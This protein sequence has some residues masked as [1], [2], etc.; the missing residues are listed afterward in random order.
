MDSLAKFV[1]TFN[2]GSGSCNGYQ[3]SVADLINARREELKLSNL[4]DNTLFKY[5][6]YL[7]S[8]V[9]LLGEADVSPGDVIDLRGIQQFEW[10]L[11][12]K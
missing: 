7:P 4:V 9:H 12:E 6:K 5:W 1:G 10:H 2:M 3:Q 11:F 8:G